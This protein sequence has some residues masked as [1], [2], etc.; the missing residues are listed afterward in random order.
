MS[1]A[2]STTADIGLPEEKVAELAI[3][4]NDNVEKESD[5]DEDG[6]EEEGAGEGEKTQKKKRKNKKKNKKK[7][8]T[9]LGA[10]G[11]TSPPSIPVSQ[12]FP[13]N[14]YS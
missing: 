5:D 13:N 4:K 11:Q 3:D 12:L 2:D 6:E 1:V 8:K 14:S 7:K 10:A 9:G